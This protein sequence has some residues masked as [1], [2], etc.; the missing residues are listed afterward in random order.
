MKDTSKKLLENVLFKYLKTNV[1]LSIQLLWKNNKKKGK[2]WYARSLHLDRKKKV[3][4]R[5]S[6]LY[7]GRQRILFEVR[8]F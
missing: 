7:E 8:T 1:E 6:V 5:Y 2:S 3:L 4:L